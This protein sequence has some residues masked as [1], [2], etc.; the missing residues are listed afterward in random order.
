MADR[1]KITDKIHD[2]DKDA[3]KQINKQIGHV[4]MEYIGAQIPKEL[5]GRVRR[6][7]LTNKENDQRPSIMR[8][9]VRDAL[10]MWL[11]AKGF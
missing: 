9:I 4:P 7:A 2:A 8:D 1:K 11:D 3:E 10:E 5:G 6:A